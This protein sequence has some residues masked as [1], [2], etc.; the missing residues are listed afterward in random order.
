M[1]DTQ[2]IIALIKQ[3]AEKVNGEIIRQ[4]IKDEEGEHTRRYELYMQYKQS[5]DHVAIYDRTF[6]DEN[7]VNRKLPNDFF[8]DIV[9][10]KVGYLAGKPIT[11]Q[12]DKNPYMAEDQLDEVRYDKDMVVVNDFLKYNSI[13]DIDSEIFKFSAICGIGGRLLYIDKEGNAKLMNLKPWEVIFIFDRS[14]DELQYAARYYDITYHESDG[15]SGTRKRVEWYDS[16]NITFWLET[17]DKDYGLDPTEKPNPRPHMFNKVPIFAYPNN[18]ECQS[19]VEKVL[20]LING[21][22][23]TLSD[24]NSE[25]EQFRL[26]YLALYGYT[27]PDQEIIDKIKKTGVFGI[28]KDG[29]MEFVT[30]ELDDAAIEHHLDRLQQSI[31][32]LSK[33][34]NFNDEQFGGNLSGVA[35]KFKVFGLESKSIVSERKFQ[36]TSRTMFNLLTAMWK[37]KG[38]ADI[39]PLDITMQFTRNFPLNLGDE[40]EATMKLKGMISE[41]TRL[42]LLSFVEDADKEMKQMELESE[43][44]IDLDEIEEEEPGGGIEE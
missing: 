35:M 20:E 15:T 18:T 7:K 27:Q 19:D 11:Y 38:M 3:N 33:S 41:K 9:D 28:D 1:Q 26:A 2:S 12:L 16:K 29:K 25:I 14:I 37:E 17:K 44:M 43:G 40:A 4:I 21:Y 8:G 10:T 30:K 32:Y 6:E 34:V 13:A 23:R 5:T 24:V 36:G 42:S 39:D 22:D 31:Y